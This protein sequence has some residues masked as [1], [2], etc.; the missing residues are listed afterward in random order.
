MFRWPQSLLVGELCHYL[1]FPARLSFPTP[2]WVWG[3]PESKWN[4]GTMHVS[5]P[6]DIISQQPK[7]QQLRSDLLHLY[8]HH[9]H[10]PFASHLPWVYLSSKGTP[11]SSSENLT[12]HTAEP[13]NHLPHPI[14]Q[15]TRSLA[16][17][18]GDTSYGI[19]TEAWE[20]IRSAPLFHACR[21]R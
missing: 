17:T 2:T 18:F 20:R 3:F 15:L 10:Q 5:T 1:V 14:T 21:F 9:Q 12:V 13:N 7:S 19:C 6:F 4:A 16:H 11:T 8:R